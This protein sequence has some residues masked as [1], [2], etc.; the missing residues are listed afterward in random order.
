MNKNI[1]EVYKDIYRVIIP[2]RGNP[3]KS[4]NIFVIKSGGENL[5]IDTGFNTEEVIEYTEN[6]IRDLD[7][8]LSKTT[9]YI[10]HLHSDHTGLANFFSKRGVKICMPERDAKLMDALSK[11]RSGYW[12]M[13]ESFAHIEGLGVDNLSINDHPGHKYKTGGAFKYEPKF[14][15]DKMKIGDFNFEVISLAGH[16]PG[17]CGLYDKEKSILFC[18]D[19]IL[20]KITSNIQFWGFDFGDSLGKY[21]QNVEIVK[22]LNVKHIFGSHRDL[23]TDTNAR[24]EEIYAHH[25]KRLA[26]AYKALEDGP[27]TV[28]DVTVR[29]KWDITAKDWSEFPDSQKWFAVGEAHSH[30]EHLRYLGKVDFYDKNGD[31]IL[32]YYIKDKNFA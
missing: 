6:Y 24:I 2:L 29:M 9:L 12:D 14:P 16:T 21:L 4:I 28:R 18:G 17:M 7:I 23:I 11:Q 27:K 20:F 26:E 5:I 32:Y 30:L 13:I 1:K 15:G 8:D 22:N 31:G 3:L 25:E 10:T 19:H